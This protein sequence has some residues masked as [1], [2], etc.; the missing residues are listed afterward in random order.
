MMHPMLRE[1]VLGLWKIHILHH[2]TE[3]AGVV[4]N[5]MIEELREHGY[6]VSPGTLYPLLH[7]MERCGW[8]Q[9][10]TTDEHPQARRKYVI[11]RNGL[12]VLSE[13]RDYVAEL[14]TELEKG[15]RRTRGVA[16]LDST[17]R[18]DR[19]SRA[20]KKQRRSGAKSGSAT[21]RGR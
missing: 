15:R 2:A 6:N 3:D 12:A 21:R 7:R 16:A 5:H 18:L 8:L 14:H 11:T 20:G 9:S 4:G 13:L 19:R 1:I 17:A 10:G